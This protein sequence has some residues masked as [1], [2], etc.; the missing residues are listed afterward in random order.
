MPWSRRG[1]QLEVKWDASGHCSGSG[2]LPHPAGESCAG[3]RQGP[4]S[5]LH[6]GADALGHL[7]AGEERLPREWAALVVMVWGPRL[8]QRRTHVGALTPV[9]PC[10]RSAP[11][12]CFSA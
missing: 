12:S 10:A 1:A 5:R 11:L 3:T 7:R 2:G 8:E 4:E 6:A 9:A